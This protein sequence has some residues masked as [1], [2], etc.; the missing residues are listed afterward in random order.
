MPAP[1]RRRGTA[2]V[3]CNSEEQ[4]QRALQRPRRRLMNR[5][6]DLFRSSVAER[7]SFYQRAPPDMPMRIHCAPAHAHTL[8]SAAALPWPPHQAATLARMR[9]MMAW[10]GFAIFHRLPRRRAC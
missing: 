7:D 6:V 9:S 2:F 5:Q 10:C 3:K 8:P 1:D 4:V